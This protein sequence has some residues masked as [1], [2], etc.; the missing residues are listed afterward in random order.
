MST[1]LDEQIKQLKRTIAEMESQRAVLGEATVEAALVP[2]QQ[3]LAEPDVVNQ[4]IDN[5]MNRG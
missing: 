5:R 1:K 4:L 3:K 2:L